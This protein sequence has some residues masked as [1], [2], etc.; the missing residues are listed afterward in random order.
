[1]SYDYRLILSRHPLSES[2]IEHLNQRL[3]SPYAFSI[4]HVS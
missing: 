3:S 4:G 1:M 2:L